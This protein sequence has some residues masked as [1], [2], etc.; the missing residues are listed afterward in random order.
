MPKCFLAPI[1]LVIV[2]Y[3]DTMSNIPE[4]GMAVVVA[5]FSWWLYHPLVSAQPITLW[6]S[7]CS[8]VCLL[9]AACISSRGVTISKC[10]ETFQP[11]Q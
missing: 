1:H 4:V 7:H 11:L 8:D 9:P 5:S 10:Y 2:K 6:S 3:K